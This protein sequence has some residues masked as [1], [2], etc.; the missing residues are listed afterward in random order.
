MR[1]KK[2]ISI[3]ICILCLCTGCTSVNNT[4]HDSN[5]VITEHIETTADNNVEDLSKEESAISDR[6]NNNLTTAIKG[7]MEVHFI[8]VGQGDATLVT[9]D[10][11]AML[12][13]AGNNSKGTLIQSYLQYNNIDTLD[14]VIGTH[15]DA[16]HIGGLD[17]IIY[18]FNCGNIIMPDVAKDTRT[19]KDVID[20]VNNKGYKIISPV[21]GTSYSLGKAEFTIISPGSTYDNA[22]DSSVGIRLTHGDNSFLLIGDAEE[23]AEADVLS[24]GMDISADVLKISHHG[25]KTGTSTAFLNGVNPIV[26]VISVGEGNTYGHPHI[27]VLNELRSKGISLYRT[28]EQGTIV[29]TSDG[30][31]ITWNCSPSDSWIGGEPIG[32]SVD[33]SESLI[34]ETEN[35]TDNGEDLYIVNTNTRKFHIPSCSSVSR[36]ADKNKAKSTLTKEEL[37]NKGYSPCENCIK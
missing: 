16:D 36:M 31:N 1:Y 32:S 12:I 6:T 10:G 9:C 30:E 35:Y 21:V 19:Y 29:A 22:N 28:D 7:D 25:S 26:A 18:K 34:G 11:H 23:E 5:Q 8:D 15:P 4:F 27:E 14:Y 24:S 37:I 20:T 2:L 17:V 33:A 13:D 3:I